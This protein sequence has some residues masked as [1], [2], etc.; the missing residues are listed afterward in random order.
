MSSPYIKYFKIKYLVFIIKLFLYKIRYRKKFATCGFW[1]GFE[2]DVRLCIEENGIIKLGQKV[3]F[4]RRT[5]ITSINGKL[6]IGNNVSFNKDCT[7]VARKS[8]TI[9]DYCNIG[10]MVSIYDHDHNLL[11]FNMPIL[12]QGYSSKPIEIGNYVW[13]GC[14]VFIKSGVKIG[15]NVIIGANSVVTRDIPDKMIA[16][17]NPAKY[18]PIQGHHS[19]KQR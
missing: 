18:R 6:T 8:I 13:I 15:N 4:S 19:I 11:V 14:K 1:Y 12:E 3:Y 7:I 2:K 5:D 9:G 17:G 16:Y 10:E